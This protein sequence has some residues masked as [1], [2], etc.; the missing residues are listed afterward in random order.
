MSLIF[1]T[2]VFILDSLGQVS[3]GTALEEP[4]RVL[5]RS[6]AE[7]EPLAG[8]WWHIALGLRSSYAHDDPWSALQHG[9]AIRP[10]FEA[11]GGQLIYVN[12]QLVR[13]MNQWYLGALASA[14]QTLEGIPAADTA[15]GM[16]SSLRRLSLSWLYADRGTLDE[17]RALA[18]QLREYGRA[19][20]DR[21]A[22]S[23][24]CWVLA[25]VLRR[26][27]EFEAAEREIQ[28]A[29]GMTMPL[30][31]PGVLA[32]HAALRLAQGRA[33]EALAIADEAMARYTT[34]G[35]C[36]MFRGAFVRLAHA[37]ALHAT[38][39]HDVARRA[40]ADARARLLATADTIADPD[41][42]ASFLSDV[43][44][45]ARTLALAGAWLGDPDPR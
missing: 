33:A 27:G 12:M 10:V 9:D 22:E 26:M 8:V 31:H 5:V 29:L 17:A 20:R 43:P 14:V 32:T 45:N 42:K 3:Q 25:E 34:M 41:Y 23:R 18:A 11:I 39:A 21:M 15:I 6:R 35:G 38:G 4:F 40:I 7:Q 2:R 44:E 19:H 36:S 24:G 28:V 16:A 30:E 1:L 37:E 13:G